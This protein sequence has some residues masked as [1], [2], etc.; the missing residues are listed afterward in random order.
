MWCLFHSPAWR[1]E[2]LLQHHA[3]GAFCPRRPDLETLSPVPVELENHLHLYVLEKLNQELLLGAQPG[4]ALVGRILKVS[5]LF[6]CDI[7]LMARRTRP[8]LRLSP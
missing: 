4:I 8:E 6:F 3:L 1:Q 2:S 5:G 7:L